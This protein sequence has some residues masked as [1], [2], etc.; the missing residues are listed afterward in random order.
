MKDEKR[1]DILPKKMN[2]S[3][4]PIDSINTNALILYITGTN[5]NFE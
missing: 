5:E 4:Q 2:P 1:S 3:F